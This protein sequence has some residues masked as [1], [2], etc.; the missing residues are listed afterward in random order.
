M[1]F[2]KLIWDIW[3]CIFIVYCFNILLSKG[4]NL[5]VL[6]WRVISIMGLNIFKE[7]VELI[8]EVENK[9]MILIGYL[10]VV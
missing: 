9:L 2:L 10:I 3:G 6:F 7:W 8:C 4:I 1:F 5:L